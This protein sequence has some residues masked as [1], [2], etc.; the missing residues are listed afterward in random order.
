MLQNTTVSRAK[1]ICQCH[2]PALVHC[3]ITVLNGLQ[4]TTLRGIKFRL[5]ST[6]I[7]PCSFSQILV[8]Y[9]RKYFAFSKI[10]DV[11]TNSLPFSPLFQKHVCTLIL[12][13]KNKLNNIH[14]CVCRNLNF[15][16]ATVLLLWIRG[17]FIPFQVTW[18][19]LSVRSDQ[20]RT[21]WNQ[22]PHTRCC[23]SINAA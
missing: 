1:H 18:P 8:K 2:Q 20:P 10:K 3:N 7:L 9:L 21:E 19:V 12:F 22:F 4:H 5:F 11:F 23:I 15:Q 14:V 13:E 17:Y 16:N 6:C